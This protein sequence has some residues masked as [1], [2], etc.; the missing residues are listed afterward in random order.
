MLIK[1]NIKPGLLV[2]L[3]LF[4]YQK[5]IQPFPACSAPIP[6]AEESYLQALLPYRTSM[7]NWTWLWKYA[8]DISPN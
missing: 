7:Q 8:S 1:F 4:S 6:Q 2:A 3:P 5:L